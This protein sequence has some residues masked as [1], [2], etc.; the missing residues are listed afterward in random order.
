MFELA[1]EL[2]DKGELR[3]SVGVLLRILDNYPTDKGIFGVHLVLGGVFSDLKE[4]EKAVDNFKKATDLNPK[5]EIASLGLY[6]TY[7]K[8]DRDEEAI[9]E[10]KRYLRQFPADLY[11]DTLEELLADI[12]EGYLQKFKEDIK[13]LA[14]RNGVVFRDK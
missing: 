11:K 9:G 2:R 8:L 5:S 4:H 14:K 7:T 12:E 3:D 13:E 10:L 1:T 6:V